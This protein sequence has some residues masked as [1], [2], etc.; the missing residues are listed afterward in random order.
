MKTYIISLSKNQYSACEPPSTPIKVNHGLSNYPDL[1]P[2]KKE[3]SKANREVDQLDSYKISIVIYCECCNPSDRHMQAVNR[4]LAYSVFQLQ[5][6]GYCGIY[7]LELCWSETGQEVCFRYASFVEGNLV[8]WN[9]IINDVS[10]SS[11]DAKYQA[12][13][14]A[15]TQF[16]WLQILLSELNLAQIN[17]CCFSVITQQLLRQQITQYNMV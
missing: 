1:I 14:H 9:E 6:S 5:A 16:I 12:L 13:H 15:L 4:I 8:T 7:K 11:V 2:T 10:L 3:K 17:T